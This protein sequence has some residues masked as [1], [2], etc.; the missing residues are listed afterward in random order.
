MLLPPPLVAVA[1]CG[2]VVVVVDARF[3]FGASLRS[4]RAGGAAHP[5]LRPS[6]RR[7]R[8]KQNINRTGSRGHRFKCLDNVS[9]PKGRVSSGPP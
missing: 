1:V 3:C 7:D 6:L 2:D 5:A 4:G 8:R 9:T